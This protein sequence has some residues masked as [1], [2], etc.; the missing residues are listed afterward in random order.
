MATIVVPASVVTEAAKKSIENI[1]KY[2]IDENERMIET[3]LYNLNNS[4]LAKLL[5]KSFTREQAK[6]SLIEDQ[7][8]DYP[9]FAYGGHLRS[10]KKLAKLAE[11]GDPVT[12][13]EEDV[14]VLFS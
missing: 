6:K 10:L 5:K 8:S 11:H 1:E 7:W 2:R 14:D 4:F 13:N 12:L 3:R 9:S